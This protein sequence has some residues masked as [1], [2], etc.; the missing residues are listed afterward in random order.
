MKI[1][2]IKT[3]KIRVG[4]FLVPLLLVLLLSIT[5]TALALSYVILQWTTTATVSAN[6]KVCF[7]KWSDN[8]KQNTFDYA[9][10]IFPS[11]KTIDENITYGIWCWDT[12]A[13]TVYLRWYSLTNPTNIASLNITIYNSA[14]TIYTKLWSSVP[15]FPTAW[16]SFNTDADTK[17]TIWMEITASSSASGTS[18][19]TFELK[20]E[21]P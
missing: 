1:R 2:E 3:R 12:S 5:G 9:V 18:T 8:T 10:Y 19:F 16:E 21:N 17:Y 6:P 4:K 20:V 14:T 13:H 11:I 15:S 7:V